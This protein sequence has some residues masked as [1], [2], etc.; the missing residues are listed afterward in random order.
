MQR[1]KVAKNNLTLRL[2]V[3]AYKIFF[4]NGK[5]ILQF[6]TELKDNNNREWFA[7]NKDKYQ[8]ALADFEQM[9]NY[10]IA[11]VTGFDKEIAGVQAKDCI[12]RIYRDVR[13]SHD[14]S[15]Y[16]N[17][18]GAYICAGGGRKSERAGYYIHFELGGC[19]FGGGLYC[20]MPEV[21][22]AVRQSVYDNIEEFKEIVEEKTFA[23]TFSEMEDK[24][25]TIPRAFPKDFP[26]GDYLK[27]KHYVF[28]HRVKDEFFA[29]DDCMDKTLEV[30]KLMYP[31]N[32]F[33][34]YT[35]DEIITK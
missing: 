17:H 25:K 30:F 10:L 13:F 32:K 9:V 35:V 7:A 26:D 29:T 16:K 22:K 8:R 21:L 33:L 4:M 18:F 5:Y 1:Q 2:H 28:S 12:F 20:P 15:P 19:M 23:A 24:L 34:N 6:L 3:F 11:H 27:N 14:K 31:I